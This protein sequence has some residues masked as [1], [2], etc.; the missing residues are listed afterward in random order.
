MTPSSDVCKIPEPPTG[1]AAQGTGLSHS[2]HRDGRLDQRKPLRSQSPH[3]PVLSD[4]HMHAH[5]HPQRALHH[6]PEPHAARP[7]SRRPASCP[8]GRWQLRTGHRGNSCSMTQHPELRVLLLGSH[9]LSTLHG[10]TELAREIKQAVAMLK[11]VELWGRAARS[12]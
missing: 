1:P 10:W 12:P 5:T 2:G 6:E 9:F 7:R 11:R 3:K 4:T 8:A